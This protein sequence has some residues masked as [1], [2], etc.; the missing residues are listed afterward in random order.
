MPS[1]SASLPGR[2]PGGPGTSPLAEYWLPFTPNRDF[3]KS[4]KLVA[5]AEGM[6]Y[7][8]PQGR[9]IIDGA[10][11]LFASAAGHGRPEIADAVGRQLREL[12][13]TSSFYRSH[14]LA[15]AAAHAIAQLT[16][17]RL[18]R[19]FFVNSGSEAVDTAMKIVLAYHRA[20]GEGQRTVF[21]SRERAYHGVN[22]GGV[23][24]SGLVNNRRAFAGVATPAPLLRHTWRAQSAFSHGQPDT[25]ADLADDLQR[26]IDVHGAEN[27]AAVFVEPIAGSTGV[28]VPPRGYL[29]RLRAI[30]DTHGLLLVFDEVITGFGRTGSAF[31]AQSFKVRPDLITMAKAITNGAQPMGA[32]AVDRRIHDQV[33]QSAPEDSIELFHGYTW[34]AHPAACAACVAALD[35]YAREQ[36]FARGAELSAYFQKRLFSLADLPVVTDIRAYGLLAGVE[37]APD[38]KPGQRGYRLQKELFDA[39]MHLKTTGDVA[40]LAP[41]LVAEPAHVDEIVDVLRRVLECHPA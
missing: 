30:C 16:P 9:P 21:I 27:I 3:K 1:A 10:S 15:F 25:G 6:Y 11:G 7:Y 35:I 39:G 4:P 28:L 36:L 29:E 18:D 33:V 38:G 32:V 13:F 19:I 22:F 8:D 14:P 24:L 5:R 26:L 20:R 37:L 23:S 34:S 12:D 41:A 40:I 31:A 17:E 2:D